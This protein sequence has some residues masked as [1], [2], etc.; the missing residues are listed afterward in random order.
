[1]LMKHTCVLGPHTSMPSVNMFSGEAA[2]NPVDRQEC[3]T[4][5][6]NGITGHHVSWARHIG[7]TF[8]ATDTHGG[9][10]GGNTPRDGTSKSS[11]RH[12]LSF[13]MAL[14]F[15]HIKDGEHGVYVLFDRRRVLVVRRF[16][17]PLRTSAPCFVSHCR[18][19]SSCGPT[20]G[21]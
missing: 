11:E 18:T 13:H 21:Q 4:A 19:L 9:I 12:G 6:G 16:R 17:I 10:S 2:Y 8:A 14:K 15:M 3:M 20:K 1:M 5:I 7:G